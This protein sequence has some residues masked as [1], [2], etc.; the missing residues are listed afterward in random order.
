MELILALIVASSVAAGLAFATARR[1]SPA[2]R[3]L[4]RL[5]DGTRVPDPAS[6]R[7]SLIGDDVNPWLLRLLG[8]LAIQSSDEGGDTRDRLRQRL[9]ESGYR[10]PSA[11][12]L[13]M[14]SR[15]AL[16]ITVPLCVMLIPGAWRLEQLQLA[17][18]LLVTTGF[19]YVFPS[20]WVDRC[21]K[22]RQ[23]AL[24]HGL[25]DALDLMVVCVQA[26]LGIIAS[27]DRVVQNLARSKPI[28]SAE[29]ELTIY[30]IRAGKSTTDGLRA[31]ANRT[32]LSEIS[33]LVAMLVQ[34]ER[35]GTSISDTLRVHADSLR[36]RRMQRAEELANKAPLKMLFPTTLIF[37]AT[38]VVS[39]GPAMVSILGFFAEH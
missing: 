16:A 2:R 23:L 29:F 25:P 18:L 27:L 8:L 5:A 36:S 26:G 15:V 20:I 30:E 6:N 7:L 34:T 21:H 12:T 19:G 14:G 38:L 11:V 22:R 3:R 17:G 39:L 4:V 31:L 10:R 33:A 32:G 24:E 1:P 9:I 35:F 37:F 13:Y 28:L